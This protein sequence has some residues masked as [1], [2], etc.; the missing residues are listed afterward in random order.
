[1][2]LLET[3]YLH[4]NG[5]VQNVWRR[6]AVVARHTM[7]TCLR[8][9]VVRF[10]VIVPWILALV[11]ATTYFAI[12]QLLVP[13]G[14]L[15]PLIP[16]M[17]GRIQTVM[18][19]IT[20]WL[21]LYPDITVRAAANLLLLYLSGMAQTISFL[22]ITVVLPRLLTRDIASNAIVIYSSRAISRFDYLS[23]K[24]AGLLGVL[25]LSW[26]GPVIAAW[27]LGNL[28]A[29]DWAFFWHSRAALLH[30][31]L[32]IVPSMVAT[33]ML[34]LAISALSSRGRIVLGVWLAVWLLTAA[35]P[36]GS[37]SRPWLAYVSFSHSLKQLAVAIFNPYL[38]FVRARESLPFFNTVFGDLKDSTVRQFGEASALEPSIALVVVM[39]L[40]VLILLRRIRAL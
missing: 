32:T 39:A 33:A 25:T 26:L 29:P 17:G 10:L 31:L 5:Q 38:D 3:G 35:I 15:G 4:W 24:L 28:V 23:G 36:L 34:A 27:A 19:G 30:S 18:S 7:K 14:L 1:M 37:L 21:A 8:G 22:I 9:R 11:T 2:A 6:R 16:M 40:T 12:G 13:D 20:A